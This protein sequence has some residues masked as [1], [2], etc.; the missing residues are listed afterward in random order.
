MC[1]RDRCRKWTNGK[2]W[3]TTGVI[4]LA[5]TMGAF[6]I[7]PYLALWNLIPCMA[8]FA[9]FYMMFYR[10]GRIWPHLAAALSVL[11]VPVIV[12]GRYDVTANQLY[13]FTALIPL[14]KMCIR[15]RRKDISFL[16]NGICMFDDYNDGKGGKD[17]CRQTG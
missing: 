9:V 12:A 16:F 6:Y 13:A 1:I 4:V 7:N 2:F 11:P 3:D 8:S 15:D 17:S 14:A 10:N 5:M